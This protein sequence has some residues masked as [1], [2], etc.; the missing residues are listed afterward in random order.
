M[1]T[2]ADT[3]QIAIQHH[4]AGRLPVAEQTYRQ[5]LAIDPDHIDALHLVGVV[6]YQLGNFSL[7]IDCIERAVALR[8][9]SADAHYNLGL[10]HQAFKQFEAAIV[11]FTNAL[12]LD[13]SANTATQY[14]L[15]NALTQQ[16]R[17]DEA[18]SVT[19]VCSISSRTIPMH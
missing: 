19:G 12:R 8:P 14:H 10:A 9:D 6:L 5:I 17:F 15:G 1:A 3:L 18:W 4:Q 7:A 2:I 16:G 11:C 13:P